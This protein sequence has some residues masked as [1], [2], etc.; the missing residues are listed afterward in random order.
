[1]SMINSQPQEQKRE[2]KAAATMPGKISMILSFV[3]FD[4]VHPLIRPFEEASDG[5]E[6]SKGF[7]KASHKRWNR[8][9]DVPVH[10]F[11]DSV[12]AMMK[13]GIAGRKAWNVRAKIAKFGTSIA[14]KNY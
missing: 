5:D 12:H 10:R 4:C 1:M 3:F 14:P 2:K 11:S 6:D 7:K 13:K 9:K 8:V